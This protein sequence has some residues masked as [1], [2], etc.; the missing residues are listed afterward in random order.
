M[1]QEEVPMTVVLER[2]KERADYILDWYCEDF[3]RIELLFW[4][5]LLSA[6]LQQEAR[7]GWGWWL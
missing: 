7:W 5:M 3:K 4:L 1:Q 2:Y 6:I